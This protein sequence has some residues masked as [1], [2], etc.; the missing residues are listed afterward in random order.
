MTSPDRDAT[1]PARLPHRSVRPALALM[2]VALLATVGCRHADRPETAA[3]N[4]RNEEGK[5]A[6]IRPI[7][8]VKRDIRMTVVQ[9][10]TLQA[11]EVTPIYSR[12]AGYVQ[13]Y[14][15][16]IGDRVK[17]GDVLIEM[18]VPDIVEQDSQAA[19]EVKRAEVQVRVTQSALRSAEAKLENMI[20]RIAG[21][22]AGVKRAQ[23]SYT[24]W[25]SEYKRLEQLVTQRVLDE[26]VRD[27]T[28][29]QFEEAIAA[30]EQANAMVSEAKAARDQ[31]AADLERARVN[32]EAAR[33]SSTSPGRPSVWHA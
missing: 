20:A 30:R 5:T 6:G 14:L 2:A 13:K 29:R 28:Y 7:H 16:N 27:E 25:E 1:R 8:P 24:R 17:A 9:P 3:A 19:A 10:G 4:A 23:A 21:A 11:F 12:I 32:V 31:A 18:W 15:Y 22:E 26:Q 33:R